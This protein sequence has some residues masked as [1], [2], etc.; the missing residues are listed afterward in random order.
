MSQRLVRHKLDVRPFAQRFENSLHCP[1]NWRL[2]RDDA[3]RKKEAD[4]Q[5]C[6]E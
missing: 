6:W 2:G 5:L 4:A 1:P 3:V